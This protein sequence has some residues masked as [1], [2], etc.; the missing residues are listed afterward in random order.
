MRDE[1]TYLIELKPGTDPRMETRVLV[2]GFITVSITLWE[3]GNVEM[4][5]NKKMIKFERQGC[6]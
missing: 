5:M 4:I 1:H 3:R 6:M 2:H